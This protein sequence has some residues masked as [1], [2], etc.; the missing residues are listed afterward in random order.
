MK[1]SPDPWGMKV[2]AFREL[3]G[4]F[5]LMDKHAA[6]VFAGVDAPTLAPVR[7]VEDGPVRTIVEA[8]FAYGRSALCL[9]YF[10][11][12]EGAELMIQ[13]RVSWC[14]KDS[15][16]KF[17]LPTT[18][19]GMRVRS[20]VAYGVEAHTREAE[21]LLWHAWLAAV[22]PDDS[23]ALTVINDGV[24][25]FDFS[26]AELRLSCLR[27]P[28]Y[29]GHPVD[30][31]TPVVRQDR[32]EP[33]VDQGE[34]VFQFWLQGG[35]ADERLTAIDREAAAKH[36]VPMALN[37]FPRGDGPIVR[38]GPTLSDAAVQI[39]AVK[40]SEDGRSMI[41]RLF[42]PT[43]TTRTTT[44]SIPTLDAVLDVTLSPFEIRTLA[45]NLATRTV[46]VVDLMERR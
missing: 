12:R 30:D 39:T 13:A 5:R 43:G 9:R 3:A 36:D 31:V 8:L 7:I 26:G 45:I 42:E 27:S 44:L 10:L 18:I 25:G 17:A 29:A 37:V 6:A 16:L 46:E 22:S 24:Y 41:V 40:M 28:A 1:D 20:Q 2:R 21:E 38:P 35:P 11:P 23:Q 15:M 32:F 19:R 4:E 33:R 34:H 14:E